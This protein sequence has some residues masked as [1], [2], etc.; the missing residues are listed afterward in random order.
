MLIN[1]VIYLTP[2]SKGESIEG[3][4][5]N[6]YYLCPPTNLNQFRIS[7]REEC[8]SFFYLFQLLLR[9]K[10]FAF[11]SYFIF[12]LPLNFLLLFFPKN[13]F[14]RLFICNIFFLRVFLCFFYVLNEL[15]YTLPPYYKCWKIDNHFFLIFRTLMHP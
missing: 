4:R 13:P 2:K 6:K 10:F 3:R 5:R 1:P 9:I 14:L 15:Q 12:R 7:L 11:T 8:L